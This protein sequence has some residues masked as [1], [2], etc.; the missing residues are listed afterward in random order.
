M[1]I[2]EN[3]S[4]KQTLRSSCNSSLSTP[5]TTCEVVSTGQRLLRSNGSGYPVKAFSLSGLSHKHTMAALSAADLQVRTGP[6]TRRLK[7]SAQAEVFCFGWLAWLCRNGS[8]EPRIRFPRLIS[9][10]LSQQGRSK[11]EH[12]PTVVLT[13]PRFPSPVSRHP[14]QRQLSRSRP[15]LSGAWVPVSLQP[16]QPQCLL[17]RGSRSLPPALSLLVAM[18]VP[19]LF[20]RLSGR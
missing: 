19:V 2:S 18:D 9:M 5:F 20:R 8:K 3:P 12:C 17:T 11:T 15:Q 6:L 14:Q 13:T 4:F 7:P 10:F 16:F 1:A